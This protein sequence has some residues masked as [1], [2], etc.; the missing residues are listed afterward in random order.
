MK[1]EKVVSFWARAMYLA[2]IENP[3]NQKEIFSNLK[4]ALSQKSEIIPAIIKKFINIY[5]KEQ[6][7]RVALACEITEK[8]KHLI[9]K[10]A[11]ELIGNKQLDYS[12]DSSL[13]AGFRLE[14]K[15][16]LIKASLKD[17]LTGL[18]NKIYGHN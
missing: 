1:K 18:K 9:E 15:D 7:A 17:V 12:I 4:S 13:L 8:E 2:V 14:T 3:S 5:L 6:K 10:K 16:V 11:K